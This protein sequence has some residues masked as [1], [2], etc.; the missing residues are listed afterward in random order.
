MY[1]V[2]LRKT[3]G[4]VWLLATFDYTKTSTNPK[5]RHFLVP[6]GTCMYG[7]GPLGYVRTSLP[8]TYTNSTPPSSKDTPQDETK[9]KLETRRQQEEELSPPTSPRSD[10]GVAAAAHTAV[11]HQTRIQ[12]S[13]SLKKKKHNHRQRQRQARAGVGNRAAANIT[14]QSKKT[15][16]H[17]P[18]RAS[19]EPGATTECV[20]LRAINSVPWHHSRMVLLPG[21]Q[22]KQTQHLRS[23]AA[24]VQHS[25][26]DVKSSPASPTAREKVTDLFS[27]WVSNR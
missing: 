19:F 21:S 1:G 27:S 15:T 14:P 20:V 4:N 24:T 16:K 6:Q 3:A 25:Q 5:P 10:S 22:K 23:G 12:T 9:N 13:T 18:E 2:G 8:Y 17:P 26:T 7:K 11:V